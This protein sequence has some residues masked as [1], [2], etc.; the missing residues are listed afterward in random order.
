MSVM[1]A[2]VAKELVGHVYAEAFAEVQSVSRVRVVE[3]CL[4]N[5]VEGNTPA[6]SESWKDLSSAF[7]KQY[8]IPLNNSE[9]VG[10]FFLNSLIKLLHL[11]CDLS[12]LNKSKKIFKEE[13]ILQSGF[14]VAIDPKS[15]SYYRF[16]TEI[17]E[18]VRFAVAEQRK[19][20]TVYEELVQ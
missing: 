11:T 20:E 14:V 3:D 17:Q 6:S 13:G 2:K 9:V 12:K 18:K 1:A 8:G 7:K 4:R 5:F 16:S 10:G 15:K 19:D